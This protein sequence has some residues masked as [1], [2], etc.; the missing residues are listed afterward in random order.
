MKKESNLDIF[1][2]ASSLHTDIHGNANIHFIFINFFLNCQLSKRW[3]T[4][5]R[6]FLS[7]FFYNELP[8]TLNTSGG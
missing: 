6:L 1:I 4:K 3:C 5:E 8:R 2:N 7:S